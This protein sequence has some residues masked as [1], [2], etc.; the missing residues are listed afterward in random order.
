MEEEAMFI[1]TVE[2]MRELDAR[3]V[4]EYGIGEVM[5]MENAGVAAFSVIRRETVIEAARFAIVCGTGN[6]GGDG[7]VL[8]RML[9][10]AGGDVTVICFGHHGSF[11]GA[12]RTNYEIATKI[13]AAGS[14]TT[15][16]FELLF[17][18]P[19]HTLPPDFSERLSR[20]DMIVDAMFGTGLSRNVDGVFCEAIDAINRSG[21]PVLSLDIPSGIAGDTGA[22]MGTAV[23]ASMTV[24]F[25]LPKLGNLLFPGYGHCGRL[26]LSHISFPPSLYDDGSIRYHVNLPRELPPRNQAGHKGS[27]GDILVVAG[28]PGYFGAPAFA[29]NAVLRGGAGYCR[30]A[31]PRAVVP[32][33]A[34]LAPGLVFVPLAENKAGAVSKS[35]IDL[36]LDTANRCDMVIVGPGLST[37]AKT[38][39]TVRAFAAA[40]EKPLLVDGDAL[41]AV[42]AGAASSDF[43]KSVIGERTH[44]TVLTPHVG[45]MARLTGLS[46]PEVAERPVTVLTETAAALS[47]VIVLKGAHSLIGYP[48][49]TVFVNPSGNAGMATAGS[50]DVL[51]GT[52]GAMY[53]LGLGF[54]QAVRSG[55]FVHGLAG[56][57]AAQAIGEDG[58]TAQDILDALPE[59]V[60]RYREER[61]ELL[62]N[63]YGTVIDV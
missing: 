12:A 53:G 24:T 22:V 52:I 49:G 61:D 59:A 5:L 60:R 4:S 7:L 21:R 36:L 39:E 11:R 10:S 3:A 20:S 37:D 8:A 9:R 30:L 44:P 1:S 13:A 35:N 40:V 18:D 19:V 63:A 42:A 48:D 6:N 57:I 15:P 17:V 58:I 27:F 26:F 62:A 54:E 33:I 46:I 29:G 23:R 14:K 32:H 56:D 55:V 2:R 45:E 51:A 47:S 28:A 31:A 25:G 38:M 43:A 34:A 50:G 41:T 16:G